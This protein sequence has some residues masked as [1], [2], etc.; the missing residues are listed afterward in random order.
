MTFMLSLVLAGMGCALIAL[1]LGTGATLRRS[2]RPVSEPSRWPR[3]SVVLPLQ[4]A[5]PRLRQ[6]LESVM[7]QDYPEAEWIFVTERADDGAVP[8]IDRLRRLHGNR[9]RHVVAGTATHCGQKNHSLLAGVLQT[10]PRTE[11]LVFCDSS[12]VADRRWLRELLRPIAAGR[13]NIATSY[14]VVTTD[15]WTVAAA[16]RA[17]AV[18]F[19]HALQLTPG[20]SQTWG[21]STAIRRETFLT[22][23][24][25][26]IWLRT[27]V[28]DVTLSLA[29]NGKEHIEP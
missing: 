11:V 16:G 1:F 24:I 25:A 14:H 21:G 19:M 29:V 27:V 17:M 22:R 18:Q 3:A 6:C 7:D 26:D 5:F 12:H 4:H 20:L 23:D 8:E 10:S 13:T 2:A 9:V 28:D 15:S